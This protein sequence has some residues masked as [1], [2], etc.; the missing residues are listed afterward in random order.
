MQ[1]YFKELQKWEQEQTEKDKK[2][3]KATATAQAAP[4]PLPPIRGT[5]KVQVAV[6]KTPSREPAPSAPRTQSGTTPATMSLAGSDNAGNSSVAPQAPVQ[7]RTPQMEFDEAKA[8]GNKAFQSGKYEQAIDMYSQCL[9]MDVCRANHETASILLS[10]RAIA[11][12]K[13][14]KFTKAESDCTESIAL[15]STYVKSWLRRGAARRDLK[16]F[17]EALADFEMVQKLSPDDQTV[18]EEINRTHRIRDKLRESALKS[19]RD[20]KRIPTKPRRVINIQETDG[21]VKPQVSFDSTDEPSVPSSVSAPKPIVELQTSHSKIHDLTVGS[22]AES[23]QAPKAPADSSSTAAAVKLVAGRSITPTVPT[24]PPK[25]FYELQRIWS[26]FKGDLSLCAK[27]LQVIPPESFPRLFRED[28]EPDMLSNILAAC[29]VILSRSEPSLTVQVL[30]N[31]MSVRR[32]DVTVQFLESKDKT[33]IRS[34]LKQLQ[35]AQVLSSDQLQALQQSYR[36]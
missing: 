11:Y 28:L 26:S 24:V 25:T 34:T 13:V 18:Q 9:E 22:Q 3:K 8:K 7:P 33:A 23:S 29:D 6:S 14:G 30:T 31:L 2:L 12:I 27:Y 19:L 16:K 36:V 17:R 1:E 35:Q 15:N 10:N 20:V 32:F 5:A 21:R 4:K